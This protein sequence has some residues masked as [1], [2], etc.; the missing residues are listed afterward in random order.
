[1]E[2]TRID[3]K[4]NNCRSVGYGGLVFV[5]G[6]TADDT[7]ADMAG[8]TRQALAKI[9][10]HLA[11]AGTDKSRLLAA[12]V[13]VADMSRKEEMNKAW[14]DWIDPRNPPTRATVGATLT[15][16]TLVEIV[17]IAGKSD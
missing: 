6:I 8:Q 10:R 7:S 13:Y 5:S 12:T 17:V 14:I 4:D 1:M 3:P 11:D 9:D 15:P 2:I 16:Q